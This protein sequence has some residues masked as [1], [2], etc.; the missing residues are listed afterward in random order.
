MRF[1]VHDEDGLLR[2]FW[3]RKEAVA[4]KLP[5][6]KLVV[7]PKVKQKTRA[8]EFREALTFAGEAMI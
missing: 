3:T 8:E 5:S 2:S 6:M 4:W 1:Q 7:L